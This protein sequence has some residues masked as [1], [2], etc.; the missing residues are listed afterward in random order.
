M[1]RLRDLIKGMRRELGERPKRVRWGVRT[2]QLQEAMDKCLPQGSSKQAQGWR[3]ALALA[4]C[5]LLR[6][7]EVAAPGGENFNPLQHL[8]DTKRN[9]G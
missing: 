8:S 3:A 6:G 5:M 7:G 2:Q 4:F 1:H 9:R